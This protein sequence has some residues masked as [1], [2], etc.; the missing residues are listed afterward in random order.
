MRIKR[1]R[2]EACEAAGIDRERIIATL[3]AHQPEL[4]RRGVRHA[5]L[6][7][8]IGRGGG[9]RTSDIDILIELDPQAPVSLFEYVGITQ[10]LADLFPVRV[11]VANRSSLR[12]LVRPSVERDA[13]YAF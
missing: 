3:R 9:K 12:P 13:L 1:V 7:G 10:Y 4:H 5:A 6:F 2:H 11:D 8:F